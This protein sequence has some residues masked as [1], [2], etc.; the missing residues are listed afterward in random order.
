MNS[1]NLTPL[2]RLCLALALTVAGS[3]TVAD[4]AK[5]RLAAPFTLETAAGSTVTLPEE[6]QGIGLYLFWATWC[7][8]CKAL[9]PHLQSIEDE[10]G[11]QVTVY[12]LNFRDRN[13]PREYIAKR[14]FD[15]VLL[16]EADDTADEWGAHA[17][18]ALFIVDSEGRVRFDLYQVLTE[19]PPGYEQL[20][21]SQRAERRAPFWAAR[22]RQALDGL[23]E[24]GIA[25]ADGADHG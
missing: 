3:A 11:D 23:I 17:T 22:I 25:G 14:G 19:D 24:P 4:N 9:M 10:F 21:H 16:P 1:D 12:A 2:V 15:F 13:D 7:P 5:P 20:D 8:Y 6:Q 18:P